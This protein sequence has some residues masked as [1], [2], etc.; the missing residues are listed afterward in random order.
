MS[1][2]DLSIEDAYDTGSTVS[3]PVKDFYVPVLVESISYDRG[4]GYFSSTFL[5]LAARCIA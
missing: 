5:A 4:T 3:G 1:F 2:R